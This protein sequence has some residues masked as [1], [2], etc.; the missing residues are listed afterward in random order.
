MGSKVLIE[1]FALLGLETYADAAP[2]DVEEVLASLLR[3]KEKAL[4]FLEHELGR[5]DSASLEWVRREGGRVVIT[6]VPPLHAPGDYHPPV[7]DM[8]MRV[9]GPSALEDR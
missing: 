1:G 3:D 4:V 2:E 5:C 6:E 7:E 9:L 8:I